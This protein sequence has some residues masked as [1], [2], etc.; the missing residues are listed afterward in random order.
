MLSG[1]STLLTWEGNTRRQRN[2]CG[3]NIIKRRMKMKRVLAKGIWDEARIV[4]WVLSLTTALFG[5]WLGSTLGAPMR[6]SGSG[7]RSLIF[8]LI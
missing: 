6:M 4:H 5:A 7:A 8:A 2:G 1:L 3:W